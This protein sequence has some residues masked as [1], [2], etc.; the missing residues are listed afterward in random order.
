MSELLHENDHSSLHPKQQWPQ[1]RSRDLGRGVR[2]NG[3][4]DSLSHVSSKPS[5]D[6]DTGQ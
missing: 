2:Q 6:Q 5:L 4:S 1:G 3:S